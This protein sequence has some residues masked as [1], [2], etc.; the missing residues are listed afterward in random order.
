[1][2]T[3]SSTIVIYIM[4]QLEERPANIVQPNPS[5]N[6]VRRYHYMQCVKIMA[7]HSR[8]N[9][10]PNDSIRMVKANN[11]V[12]LAYDIFRERERERERE[13]QV[14]LQLDELDS[15]TYNTYNIN[16]IQYNTYNIVGIQV[17]YYL[18]CLL[19]IVQSPWY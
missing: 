18:L 15:N 7:I 9:R 11:G 2:L 12:A 19:P 3:T 1:M 4:I 14:Y 10:S 17:G 5:L 16:I 6:D 13:K 8:R